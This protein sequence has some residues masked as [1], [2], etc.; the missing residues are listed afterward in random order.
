MNHFSI[1]KSTGNQ[2]HF[3]PLSH[4]WPQYKWQNKT[5]WTVSAEI[6][7]SVAIRSLFLVTYYN[8][9]LFYTRG[10]TKIKNI[11][12]QWSRPW[13]DYCVNHVWTCCHSVSLS[14]RFTCTQKEQY[15]ALSLGGPHSFMLFTICARGK[16]SLQPL[17]WRANERDELWGWLG[18]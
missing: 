18:G 15:L 6:R 2:I 16:I 4:T 7:S 17:Q 13:G 9:C 8:N 11:F 10:E 5:L 14:K 3:S 12:I 1:S